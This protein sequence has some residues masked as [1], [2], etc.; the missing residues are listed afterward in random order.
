MSVWMR[1]VFVLG[2]YD[3]LRTRYVQ[4][5]VWVHLV[6]VF[7]MYDKLRT[8]YVQMSVWVHLVFVL[9]VYDKLRTRYVQ[10]SVWMNLPDSNVIQDIGK[11]GCSESPGFGSLS[12]ILVRIIIIEWRTFRDCFRWILVVSNY[13]C[14]IDRF[15]EKRFAANV[16]LRSDLEVALWPFYVY[17]SL[18]FCCRRCE[19]LEGRSRFSWIYKLP[20]D[21]LKEF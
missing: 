13:S 17:F 10:M 6:F 4:M 15:R 21:R 11:F 12:I 2:V 7:G 8:R 18:R 1:F 3:K 19:M 9:D 16:H 14:V 5:L 20:V